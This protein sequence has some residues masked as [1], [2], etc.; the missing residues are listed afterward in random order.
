MADDDAP[1]EGGT[2]TD[3]QQDDTT[4]NGDQREQRQDSRS[5]REPANDSAQQDNGKT[6]TQADVDRLI[7]DRLAR[8]EKKYADYG[9]LKKKATE[10]D[11]LQDAQKSEVEKLNDQLTAAQV[12]LQGFRVTEARRA[13]AEEVGLPAKWAKRITSADPKEALAEAQELKR[14]LDAMTPEPRTADFRQGSRQP[15]KQPESRDD[16]IRRMTGHA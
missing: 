10:L 6:F 2:T 11:K 3:Q 9:D 13:A 7:A 12:E 15:A 1:D 4:E 8:A 5:Q 16:L 14:D